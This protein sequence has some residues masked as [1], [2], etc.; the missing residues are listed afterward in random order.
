[1][2]TRKGKSRSVVSIAIVCMDWTMQTCCVNAQVPSSGIVIIDFTGTVETSRAGLN[3]WTPAVTN[4]VLSPGDRVRTRPLS[5][6]TL[7][8]PD[9]DTVRFHDTSEFQIQAA[10]AAKK[11]PGLSLLQGM[12]YLFHRGKPAEFDIQTPTASAAIRGTEFNLEFQQNG[13][14][15][16]TMLDGTV[17]LSNA[18]GK[19]TVN[20]FEQGIADPGIIPTRSP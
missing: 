18:Q 3:V 4:Q 6:L 15:I 11:T 19:V 2:E 14:T 13:R 9:Q 10:P 8:W 17:E 16:V 1:M 7:R 12:L 20:S 5:R